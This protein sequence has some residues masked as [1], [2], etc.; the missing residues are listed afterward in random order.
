MCSSDLTFSY[1]QLD[2]VG[3]RNGLFG[4]DTISGRAD[5][6]DA[7]ELIT[8]DRYIFLRDAYLQQREYFSTGEIEDDFGDEDFD[9]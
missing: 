7:E 2:D 4:L 3:T 6:L 8:G 5:L 9:W 1:Q